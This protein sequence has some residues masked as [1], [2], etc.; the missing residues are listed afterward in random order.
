MVDANLDDNEVSPVD[1]EGGGFNAKK[2]FLFVL[3]PLFLLAGAGGGLYFSGMLD[4]FLGKGEDAVEGEAEAGSKEAKKGAHAVVPPSAS[5]FLI[6]PDMSVNLADTGSKPNYLRLKLQLELKDQS[7]LMAVEAVLPR[8]VD[9]FQTYL[10]E[11]RVRDLRGSAGIY[12]LQMELLNRVNTAVA[13]VEVKGVLIQ[14]I[15]VQ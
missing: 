14:E 5:Y 13:P 12:R 1:D 7:D 10:R 4:K 9:Q 6:I 3:L 15:L 8:V 11:L 2:I